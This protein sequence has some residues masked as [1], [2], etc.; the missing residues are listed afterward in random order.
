MEPTKT[1]TEEQIPFMQRLLDNPYMLLFI[2][3]NVP[4]FFYTIWGVIEVA[5]IP[6]AP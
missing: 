5:N 6:L 2:G 3:L 4:T 1:E